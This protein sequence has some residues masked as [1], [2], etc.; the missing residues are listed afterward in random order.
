MAP[1]RHTPFL[2]HLLRLSAAP[3]DGTHLPALFREL[4]GS[5]L[6]VVSGCGR[7]HGASAGLR[8]Y[9][10]GGTATKWL[11]RGSATCGVLQAR[12]TLHSLIPPV[13][14]PPKLLKATPPHPVPRIS[15]QSFLSHCTPMCCFCMW[16]P[17][18]QQARGEGQ[19]PPHVPWESP[20]LPLHS[21]VPME[22]SLS[23]AERGMT[24]HH[25]PAAALPH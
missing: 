2:S 18:Q 22:V 10:G 5:E 20:A 9:R 12:S 6:P 4:R 1:Q 24:Q 8:G 11:L 16:S 3:A 25:C 23:M 17:K 7:S 19:N 13:P 14:Q 15:P 21:E